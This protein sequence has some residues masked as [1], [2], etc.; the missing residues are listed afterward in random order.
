MHKDAA[1]HHAGPSGARH[2]S[3]SNIAHCTAA[4]GARKDAQQIRQH[5]VAT[6]LAARR[7]SL[8]PIGALTLRL[9]S[10][11]TAR[12]GSVLD[13]TASRT[14]LLLATSAATSLQPVLPLHA[15][16]SHYAEKLFLAL[17]E[18]W[19]TWGIP[20]WGC[21]GLVRSPIGVTTPLLP[22][23]ERCGPAR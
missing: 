22:Q 23:S 13:A 21:V 20:P 14:I 1:S 16:F 5:G 6:T 11:S 17:G 18:S 4:L 3:R 2:K 9:N 8:S 10:T 7:S 19:G 12:Q 15:I